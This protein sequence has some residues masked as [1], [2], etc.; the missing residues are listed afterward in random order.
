MPYSMTGMGKTAQKGADFSV[1]VE[2]K[3]VNNRYLTIK[4][5]LPDL[6]QQFEP[7]LQD[8]IRKKINRGTV[9]VR[10]NI[11]RDAKRRSVSNRINKDILDHYITAVKKVRKSEGSS[12]SLYPELLLSLP[13]VVEIEE[14]EYKFSK[15]DFSVV[16]EALESALDRLLK[17]RLNEGKRLIKSIR[18]R[19]RIIGKIA[20]TIEKSSILNRIEKQKKL[21]TRIESMLDGV[22]LSKDDPTLLREIAVLVDR[23]DITEE[24]VRLT[25]HLDQFDQIIESEGE[26]GRRLDFLIQEMGREVNTIG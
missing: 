22:T 19:R 26:I 12:E 2:L 10:I 18:M 6:L 3:T 13:G 4:N 23:L 8:I 14:K 21:K 1:V 20:K 16:C 9:D 24:I 17:M 25:S 7:I 5:H 11:K 15:K